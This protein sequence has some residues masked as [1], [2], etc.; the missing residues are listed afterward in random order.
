MS[1]QNWFSGAI[2]EKFREHI[3][4]MPRTFPPA[5][6]FA[7]KPVIDRD[8]VFSLDISHNAKW[9]LWRN[10]FRT[11]PSLE[12]VTEAALLRMPNCG[13]KRTAEIMAV[14]DSLFP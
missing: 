3:E 4:Q 11:I 5:D 10:G 13:K 9:V 6:E 2:R 14:R 12:G 1:A 7:D 8:S